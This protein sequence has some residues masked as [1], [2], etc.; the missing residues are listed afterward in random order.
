MWQSIRL[1]FLRWCRQK[2]RIIDGLSQIKG[3]LKI[4]A[5]IRNHDLD[6]LSTKS[7]VQ[8]IFT[9]RVSSAQNIIRIVQAKGRND[10]HCAGYQRTARGG[11]P[12]RPAF[13]FRIRNPPP[14]LI[15]CGSSRSDAATLFVALDAVLLFRA[16]ALEK[17]RPSQTRSA[18][19]QARSSAGYTVSKSRQGRVSLY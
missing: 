2:Q 18:Q 4:P 9:R 5:Q 8:P 17:S 7:D 13:Y 11:S 3:C 1:T 19:S 14:R 15:A 12:C 10:R 16:G 6:R